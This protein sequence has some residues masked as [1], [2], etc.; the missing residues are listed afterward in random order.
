[1]E[2][3]YQLLY[4]Q[5]ELQN[6]I[7]Q[8]L[9]LTS[10]CQL[11]PV[12][13]G[14]NREEELGQC[15][16]ANGLKVASYGPHFGEEQ[17]LVGKKGS[18]TVFFTGCNLKCIYCQNYDISQHQTIKTISA[19]KLAKIFLQLQKQGCANINLVSP[20]HVV[21]YILQ[22]LLIAVE[23]GLNL[24]L[25]YNSGG[26]DSVATL[27]LL[28]GVID[29]YMP[30]FKYGCNKWGELY[31]EVTNYFDIA[32]KA[33]LEM[34]RQVGNLQLEGKLAKRGLLIRHLILPNHLQ[35]SEKV[36]SFLATEVSKEVS[37]NLMQQYYPAY[38]SFKNQKLNRPLSLAEYTYLLDKAKSLGL[39][40]ML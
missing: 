10:S 13:C 37:I 3:P 21:P 40:N 30:D 19:A 24:P 1:M 32:K 18:G 5:G 2:R 39:I 12:V 36:L 27:K 25:V 29:I 38:H 17:P 9:E 35:S 20:T 31:S 22:G 15:L 16:T 28:D 8:L 11:C 33:V 7:D 23:K 34:Y 26:Y 4:Q 14:V 6:R